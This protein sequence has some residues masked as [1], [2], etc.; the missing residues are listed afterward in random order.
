MSLVGGERLVVC[1]AV[2]YVEQLADPAPLCVSERVGKAVA[3]K[4][5]HRLEQELGVLLGARRGA[6]VAYRI[7]PAVADA[8][9][10]ALVDEGREALCNELHGSLHALAVAGR[11]ELDLQGLLSFSLRRAGDAS[12]DLRPRDHERV[13]RER[14][15]RPAFS[16]AG[17]VE[18]VGEPPGPLPQS[19]NPAEQLP[20]GV[21]PPPPQPP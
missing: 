20:R 16:L 7:G 15:P 18:A 17:R 21:L 19:T 10:Q 5:D 6:T 4:P 1:P 13:V 2:P 3:P 9:G 14:L 12:R 8:L 11:H